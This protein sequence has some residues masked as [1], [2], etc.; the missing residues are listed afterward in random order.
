MGGAIA[1]G[2]PCTAR[3]GAAVLAAG[4]NAL[5]ACLAAAFAAFVA[6]GPLTGPAGGGFLLRPG[7]RTE[8]QWCSTASSPSLTRPLGAMEELVIDF[9]DA[10]TQVFHIG[11]ESVA[12]PGLVARAG[13]RPRPL[14]AP[15]V[16]GPPRAGASSSPGTA[17]P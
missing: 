13:G 4:G 7:A 14:R 3:A 17:S 11:E 12:V 10:S 6:E 2:H 1:A 8:T 16:G 15:P 5:D 9:A